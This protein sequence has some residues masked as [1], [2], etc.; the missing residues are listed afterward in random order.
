MPWWHKS[1]RALEQMMV[2]WQAQWQA[3]PSRR[4]LAWAPVACRTPL[5][6]TPLLYWRLVPDREDTN[7]NCQC[8]RF[9]SG[10][11]RH[12]PAGSY[13]LNPGPWGRAI[14]GSGLLGLVAPHGPGPAAQAGVSAGGPPRCMRAPQSHGE[15]PK[16]LPPPRSKAAKLNSAGVYFRIFVKPID[17]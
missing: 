10:V 7:G 9:N 2:P 6:E 3:G 13:S 14:E 15:G 4:A 5:R 8:L 12:A 1:I 16:S 11:I 17:H